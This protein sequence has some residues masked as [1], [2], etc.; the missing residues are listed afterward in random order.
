[1]VAE[2]VSTDNQRER[3]SG[4][5]CLRGGVDKACH[6]DQSA[7]SVRVQD[8]RKGLYKAV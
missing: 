6:I 8:F 4:P 5:C 7:F 2:G 3:G 1:M